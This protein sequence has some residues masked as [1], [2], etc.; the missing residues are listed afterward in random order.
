MDASVVQKRQY[1]AEDPKPDLEH[2]MG[3]VGWFISVSLLLDYVEREAYR[4]VE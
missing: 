3:G 2:S 1:S 4:N